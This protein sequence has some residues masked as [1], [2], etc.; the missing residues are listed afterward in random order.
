[1]RRK[2]LLIGAIVLLLAIALIAAL[3]IGQKDRTTGEA[4]APTVSL[5]AT[6]IER[7]RALVILADCRPCHTAQGGQDFAGGRAIPTPFGTFY[8][9]NITPD[10][11]TGIGA[12]TSEDFWHAL[13]N[14]YSRDG[15]PLYPTFPYTNYTKISRRDAQ[16]MYDYLRTVQPARRAARPHQLEF[17]Y[18]NEWLLKLWRRAYF[19]P[20]VYEPDGSRSAEWNRGAYIVEGLAHCSA[21]H[22]AR[23]SLG[24][25]RSTH[26]PAGGLVLNWY[27]PSLARPEEAGLQQ[28][29]QAEIAAFLARGR[30]GDAANS[31]AHFAAA[32]GPMAEVIYESLQRAPAHELN[33]MAAYLKSIP[34]SAAAASAR[35]P[36]TQTANDATLDSGRKNYAKHCARCH[37]DNGEG[38]PPA[39]LPLAGNRAVTMT[40]ATNPAR[41]VL[42]GGYPP[43]SASNPRPFG[44]PP[45]ADAL[46][47]VE[48]AEILTYVRSAWGNQASAVTPN[49]VARNRTGPQW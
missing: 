37:G 19:R 3:S 33:A 49:D 36:V 25:A 40:N 20:G 18:N 38:R 17:P 46:S 43:G 7:G 1:M 35:D 47:N 16:D 21:C 14:G 24:A 41:I 26:N 42:Y 31:S 12:W 22:E 48:I 8:S 23:N 9:P 28:W 11:E 34:E 44:M 45:F 29:P 32:M 6:S 39:A 27:A 13:H 4:P 5:G 30:T 2:T 15:R 10:T